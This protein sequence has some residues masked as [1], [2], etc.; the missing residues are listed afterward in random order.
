MS[1]DIESCAIGAHLVLHNRAS[2][3]IVLAAPELARL[4]HED[5]RTQAERDTLASWQS[6]GLFD[7]ER[8]SPGQAIA[9][10]PLAG[11]VGLGFAAG[12]A[13]ATLWMPQDPLLDQLNCVLARY[14]QPGGAPTQP[15][16]SIEVEGDDYTLYRDGVALTERIDRD[17]ARYACILAI[18]EAL[19]GGDAVAANMHASAVARGGR[20]LVFVGGSGSGKTTTALGLMGRGWSQVADDH[21]PLHRN[22]HQVFSFPAAVGT[23]ARS[24][25]LPEVQALF[26]AGREM[27]KVRDGVRYVEVSRQVAAGSVVPVAAVIFPTHDAGADFEMHRVTPEEALLRAIEGGARV[28]RGLNTLA[29][30]ARLLDQVPAYRMVY[31]HSGQSLDACESLPEL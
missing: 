18:S 15:E 3:A 4:L 8:Y 6:A 20:A 24:W 19:V 31:S 21:V 9:A 14:A 7:A 30:L 12:A 11:K 29:P 5:P 23:K 26:T 28:S 10:R 2:G 1:A 16:L 22:G 13:R 25:A 17:A 27:P